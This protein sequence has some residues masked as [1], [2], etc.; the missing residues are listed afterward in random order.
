MSRNR[1]GRPLLTAEVGI[2]SSPDIGRGRVMPQPSINREHPPS[3]PHSGPQGAPIAENEAQE[4][5][6][7]QSAPQ[8]LLRASLGSETAA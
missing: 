4:G 8:G 5:R 7:A 3:G 6:G 2:L 1:A